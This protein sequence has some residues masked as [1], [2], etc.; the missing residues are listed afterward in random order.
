MKHLK[1][2]IMK[3]NDQNPE[4][5]MQNS[6]DSLFEGDNSDLF[7][8]LFDNIKKLIWS[9]RE[10]EVT[11]YLSKEIKNE[12][13]LKDLLQFI[14][15]ITMPYRAYDFVR[16]LDNESMMQIIIAN[17]FDKGI[18]RVD[19]KFLYDYK[20]YGFRTREELECLVKG[21]KMIC[22]FGISKHYSK[23]MIK[24]E[25]LM[26]TRISESGAD[27]FAD[28]YEKNYNQLQMNYIIEQ[29]DK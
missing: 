23:D 26:E 24:E 20:K 18:I 14:T 22:D 19:F 7:D 8:E 12:I 10:E 2:I 13:F 17:V 6:L 15:Y 5:T 21:T 29:L 27:Y 11:E 28:L 16:S 1:E 9:G 4:W 3:L 25:V